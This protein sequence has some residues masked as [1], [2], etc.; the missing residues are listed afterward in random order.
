MNM[1]PAKYLLQLLLLS[2]SPVTGISAA[3]QFA[4]SHIHYNWDQQQVTSMQQAVDVLKNHNVK[5]AIV[6]S[7]PTELALELRNKGGDWIIPFFSPY[8]HKSG[9]RDWYLD[10]QVVEK[11]EQGLEKGL[12][13]G[14]GEVHF[15]NG[16][17][18]GTDNEI[19]Q[20]L[21]KLA[22]KY[23]VPMLI[24][25]DSGNEITFQ[26][27]C[28]AN[29]NV[30]MIFAHAGGNLKPQ[31]IEKIINSCN[32]AWIDFAARDPWRYDGLTNEDSTLLADW[33]QL[34]LKYPERFITG[35][36]PV[37]KVTRWS[38]WD[39]D[40]E[41]WTWYDQLYNYHWSWLNDLPE[42]VRN[43]IAWENTQ[44]LLE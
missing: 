34:V 20:Q 1:H 28:T 43:K 33:K 30:K 22:E 13:F 18:P 9:K 6:A 3:E 14:I 19:F 4:D 36:D 40:D 27:L 29:P 26:R 5:L 32:N 11:A 41:G 24:H 17:K 39:T 25:I 8:I 15:M 23:H 31:H 35:T 37:W 2:I 42:D 12:Y 7:T 10:R 16:F 21:I 44:R 38:T